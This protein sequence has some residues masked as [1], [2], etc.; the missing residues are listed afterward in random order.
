MHK[1]ANK[2]KSLKIQKQV[3]LNPRTIFQV[4]LQSNKKTIHERYFYQIFKQ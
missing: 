4:I 2:N 3:P 1:P